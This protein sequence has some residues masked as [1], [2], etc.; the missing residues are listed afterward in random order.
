MA[1]RTT[2]KNSDQYLGWIMALGLALAGL[3]AGA[4]AGQADLAAQA[5]LP[6]A[7]PP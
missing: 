4:A 6:G 3:L 1:A 7:M 5:Q 2:M